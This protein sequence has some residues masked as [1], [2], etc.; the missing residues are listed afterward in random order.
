[1]DLS[2]SLAEMNETI[3][4]PDFR[5][6][7]V[8][9]IIALAAPGA[10]Y[11]L[12]GIHE[13][14][15]SLK[16]GVFLSIG[17]TLLF[18]AIAVRSAANEVARLVRPRGGPAVA[19]GLRLLIT[20]VGYVIVVVTVLGLLDVPLDKLLLS[21]AITGVVVG[22]AAQQSLGNAFS[23]LVLL[24]A[25]PFAVGD[26]ITLRSGALGGQY[27]GEVLAITMM[28]TIL[29]T[30]EGRMSF[31]N[32]GVL[33]AATGPRSHPTT[34]KPKPTQSTTPQPTTTS[35]EDAPNGALE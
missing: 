19:G 29:E 9:G 5:R 28:F 33:Q 14:E 16:I 21:G 23:G 7:I 2:R 1:M 10:Y 15:L 4:R 18:G 25:R 3:H 32:L 11:W 26:Y 22:I 34:T 30:E 17:A 27:D 12:G 35:D 6:A 24:F 20:V 13:P 8:A 31:P